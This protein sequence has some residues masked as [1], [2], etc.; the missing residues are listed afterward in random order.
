MAEQLTGKGTYGEAYKYRNELDEPII[1]KKSKPLPN[2]SVIPPVNI[3]EI[4]LLSEPQYPHIIHPQKVYFTDKQ[5]DDQKLIF[6]YEYGA[7][8]VC[9]LRQHY[10]R[11]RKGP[12][13]IVIAKSILFQLLLALNHL[14]Q[15]GINH[16]D[17]TPSNLIIMPLQ[18]ERPGILKLIDFGLSRTMEWRG[19]ER[20]SIV[21]TVWYRSPE[22]LLGYKQ[23]TSAIDIWAAGCI[24]AEL[25]TGKV[26]FS[27]ET[28]KTQ[29]VNDFCKLQMMAILK[30]MGSINDPFYTNQVFNHSQEF[31]QL[32]S[33]QFIPTFQTEF[34]SF[35]PD[36]IDL[37]QRMLD[38]NPEKR[39]T[40]YDALRHPYFNKKPI[41][42]MN[43]AALFPP[44]TWQ[45]LERAGSSYDQR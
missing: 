12:L 4:C 45:Q 15:H 18:Y 36:A 30:V 22:L 23:Y 16:C 40:A 44:E 24:F 37:L 33:Q 32:N 20:S 10:S 35:D 2:S 19:Q 34:A 27:T 17:V 13:D 8:D 6:T 26:L 43:I 41:P 5:K 21:V 1:I 11:E 29:N 31:M 14:H 38:V 39:I 28:Q 3:R 9:K 42:M 25:L 7:I